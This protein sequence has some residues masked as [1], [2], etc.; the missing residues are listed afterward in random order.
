[1]KKLIKKIKDTLS[2]LSSSK[3]FTLL[4]LLVVVLIIGILAGIALPQYQY[5]VM[6]TKYMRMADIARVIKDAQERYYLVNNQ[7]AKHFSD[8]DIGFDVEDIEEQD[9]GYEHGNIGDISIQ[10]FTSQA[11]VFWMKNNE[12]YMMYSLRLDN[13]DIW[14]G[15]RAMCAAYPGSGENGKKICNSFPNARNCVDNAS[16]RYSCRIY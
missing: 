13:K 7:Y 6:K 15:A 10:L 3:G 14:G 16:V 8:L 12:Y 1:M 9:T 11:E 5:S 4:E 2:I